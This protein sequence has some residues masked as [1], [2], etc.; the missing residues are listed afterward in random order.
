MPDRPLPTKPPGR[1]LGTA[2][3]WREARSIRRGGQRVAERRLRRRCRRADHA[4]CVA[5]AYRAASASRV[6]HQ[7]L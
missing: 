4:A 3:N 1:P 2:P 5:C 7:G 6:G